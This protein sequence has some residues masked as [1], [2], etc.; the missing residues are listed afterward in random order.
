MKE[1]NSC[2]VYLLSA[3]YFGISVY[4]SSLIKNYKNKKSIQILF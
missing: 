3:G 1:T 2:R 4:V